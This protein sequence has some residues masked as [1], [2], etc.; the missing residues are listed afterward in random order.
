MRG[1]ALA[2]VLAAAAV[3]PASP[4]VEAAKNRNRAAAVELIRAKSD[5]NAASADGATALHWAAQWDDVELATQLLKAGAN[6]NSRNRYGVMPLALAAT[7]GSAAM[8]DLLLKAKAEVNGALASGETPLMIAARTGKVAALRVLLA[9][10]ADV[11]AAEPE[12]GQTALMWA[13]A[14]GHT[15]A[16]ALL[17]EFGAPLAVKS[18]G[19]FTPLLFA[20]REGRAETVR[21]L[22]SKGAKVNDTLPASTRVRRG[23]QTE[24][25][26]VTGPAALDLAVANAHFELAAMLLDAGADP[27]AAGPGWTALHTITWVRKPGTGSNNPAPPGS[28]KMDSL[29][30][31]RRLAAKGANLN[32]RMTRRTAA[33]ASSLNMVGATPFLMAARTDDAELM[34]LLAKLGADPK[35]GTE[36]ESTPLMVAAGLGTRSPGEDAGTEEEALEAVQVALE[37]GNDVN[38][39]DNNGETAM[40]GAAYKHL[41]AVAQYL[42]DHGAKV[43]AFNHK[44]SHGW[45][46]LRIADGV[47]RGM[48]L[49]ASPAVAEV[50]RKVMRAAGVSTEVE[51]ETNI[52]G[53]TR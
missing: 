8:V 18:K 49:R 36:D 48:N 33:G 26:K 14:E 21:M 43:E 34:R 25:D 35:I 3:L 15:D 39:V 7:N 20:V 31:V 41:P 23:G 52:S 13:A 29:E 38:A 11:K 2:A 10:G 22:L 50:L 4:L 32:A 17:L 24:T 1:K 30:L 46:P 5:V 51:P 28:G 16:A 53:A 9:A 37:L 27:N 42:A 40:H 6:A 45:T 12:R 19:G 44:N 47:H